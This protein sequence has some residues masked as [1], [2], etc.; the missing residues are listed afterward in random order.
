M[1]PEV[2]AGMRAGDSIDPADDWEVTLSPVMAM[3]SEGLVELR[4][5]NVVMAGGVPVDV[6]GSRWHPIQNREIIGIARTVAKA[7][8]G[9]VT[10]SGSDSARSRFS[11]RVELSPGRSL[12]VTAAHTGGGALTVTPYAEEAGALVRVGGAGSRWPHGPT[13]E[14]RIGSAEEIASSTAAWIE[15]SEALI[16]RAKTT[17]LE[18]AEFVNACSGLF[19]SRVRTARRQ[20]N[21]RETLDVLAGKWQSR[22]SGE[23]DAWSGLVT[24]CR[25]LDAERPGPDADRVELALDEGGWVSRAKVTASGVIAVAIS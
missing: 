14:A 15:E 9:R 5:R 25:W 4:G 6:V 7:C 22:S 3:G 12:V 2:F 1:T 23:L 21:A 13:L 17:R 8:G 16:R 20:A 18:P 24:I 10:H 19:L 11:A